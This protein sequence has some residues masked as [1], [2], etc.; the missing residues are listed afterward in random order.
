MNNCLFIIFFFLVAV[1]NSSTSLAKFDSQIVQ[2]STDSELQQIMD[3]RQGTYRF[4]QIL[5]IEMGIVFD[6]REVNIFVLKVDGGK[7]VFIENVDGDV[8]PMLMNGQNHGKSFVGIRLDG[9]SFVGLKR[10]GSLSQEVNQIVIQMGIP[11]QGIIEY[12]LL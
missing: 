10:G 4:G 7:A 2:V 11:Y 5:G 3:D 8:I 12:F 9:L 1:L 6:N